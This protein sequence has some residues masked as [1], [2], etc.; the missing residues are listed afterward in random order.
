M[1]F[2][3]ADRVLVGKF[4]VLLLRVPATAI[5]KE[6]GTV[7]MGMFGRILAVGW[8]FILGSILL[9][10]SFPRLAAWIP[11][12]EFIRIFLIPFALVSAVYGLAWLYRQGMKRAKGR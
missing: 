3:P 11:N 5:S 12:P 6:K 8:I 7:L 4:S 10:A 1:V 2:H 9:L